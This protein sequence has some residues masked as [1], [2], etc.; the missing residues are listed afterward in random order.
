MM[1]KCNDDEIPL[2][3]EEAL[4]IA[5]NKV[6]YYD[7]HG[8]LEV[9][10]P[11]DEGVDWQKSQPC[12]SCQEKDKRI[13]S[14]EAKRMSNKC[15]GLN[16]DLRTSFT[17]IC[18]ENKKLKQ[19]ISENTDTYKECIERIERYKSI[20][21]SLEA[22]LKVAVEALKIT[23]IYGLPPH[24]CSGYAEWERARAALKEIEK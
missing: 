22:K 7:A 17:N 23:F 19:D 21:Q 20:V 13:R 18:Y 1:V 24:D 15:K 5:M 3:R 11:F 6:V 12:P 10:I 2:T 9:S 8:G 14:L 16:C 4:E